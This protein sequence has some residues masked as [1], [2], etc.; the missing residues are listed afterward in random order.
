MKQDQKQ[1]T[2]QEYIKSDFDVRV[3]ILNNEILASMR[4]DVLKGDFRS[5]YSQGA[6]VKEYKLNDQERKNLYRC[7][8]SNRWYIHMR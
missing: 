8:K 3:I 2:L 4:R 6:K 5:N 1:I 7:C